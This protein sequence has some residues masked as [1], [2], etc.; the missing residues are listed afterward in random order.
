M[1]GRSRR[2][3]QSKS[4]AGVAAALEKLN[5]AKTGA[6]RVNTFELKEEEA[7]YD[8]L[9]EETYAQV[10]TKKRIEAGVYQQ[11]PSSALHSHRG[12]SCPETTAHCH[13]VV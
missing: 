2:V 8:V 7:V 13:T 12:P 9:D 6:K 4:A 10:A 11:R 1:S 5:A 3:V